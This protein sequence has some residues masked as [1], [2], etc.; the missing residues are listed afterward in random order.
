M[1][2]N[3]RIL[4]DEVND[5]FNLHEVYY[6]PEGHPN[7]YTEQA[8]TFGCGSDEGA[9]GAIASLKMALADV[10]RLPV[11]KKLDFTVEPKSPDESFASMRDAG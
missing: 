5:T 4:H 3:Y 2:W 8:I 1:A 9:A 11:L 10:E 6:D 7:G